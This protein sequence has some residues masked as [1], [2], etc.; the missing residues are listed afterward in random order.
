MARALLRSS[1]DELRVA[2]RLA[3]IQARLQ[4][5]EAEVPALAAI[6]A[7][8]GVGGGPTEAGIAPADIDLASTA[9]FAATGATAV[10]LQSLRA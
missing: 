8:L 5:A 3:A 10:W 7:R 1:D 6:Q 4:T 2:Q 9:S